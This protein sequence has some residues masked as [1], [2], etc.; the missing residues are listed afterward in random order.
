MRANEFTDC[1]LVQEVKYQLIFWIAQFVQSNPKKCVLG[2]VQ[3]ATKP[4][5]VNKIL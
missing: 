3:V 1:D 4:Q 5:S 2:Q